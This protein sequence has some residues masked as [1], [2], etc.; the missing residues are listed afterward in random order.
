MIYTDKNNPNNS[1]DLNLFDLEKKSREVMGKEAFTYL[2]SGAEDSFTV[3]ANTNAF[4]KIEIRARR[5]I[6]VRNISTKIELFGQKLDNPIILSPVGFQKMFNPKGEIASAKAAFKKKHHMIVSSLSNFS[7][8]EIASKSNANLWF[9]LYPTPNREITKILIVQAEKAG[10]KI[11]VLTVDTPIFGNRQKEE[12]IFKKLLIP[13]RLTLANY[14]GIF[15]VGINVTDA[16][17]TWEIIDWLKEITKMK[18]VIKGIVTG[19]DALLAKENNADAIIVSNHGGRQLESNRASINC[20]EEI[21]IAVN[22]SI[23]VLMDGGIRRGTDIFKALA[24]GAK[25]I[26]IGRPY[27]W[28]LG[29]FGQQG[30]ELVLDIL[31]KELIRDMRLAGTTSI[32]KITRKHILVN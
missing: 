19:E 30:V 25:A 14:K 18:I 32:E 31:K 26:C 22:G 17:M 2:N 1:I 29:A 23:P 6:D 15:S 10:C 3:N 7:I 8:K 16:G 12:S 4:K 27:C 11:L 24:L 13:R 21:V 28:G 9:Q 5:L 20:L